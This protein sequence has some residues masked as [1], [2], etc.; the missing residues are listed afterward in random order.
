MKRF[1]LDALERA[2]K[3]AAQTAAA[4]ITD[5]VIIGGVDWRRVASVA[6]VATIASL[7]TSIGSHGITGKNSASLVSDE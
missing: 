4:V 7:L 3:T 5:A 1:W 2:I 6:A